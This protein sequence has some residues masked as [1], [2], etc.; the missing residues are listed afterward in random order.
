MMITRMD[1]DGNQ[2]KVEMEGKGPIGLKLNAI[3]PFPANAIHL[4]IVIIISL[5]C[6]Y[7]LIVII[8]YFMKVNIICISVVD[9]S[10]KKAFD[11]HI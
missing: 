5:P 3:H 1:N 7:H 4:F 2:S 8:N 10:G 9:V 6:H 11:S